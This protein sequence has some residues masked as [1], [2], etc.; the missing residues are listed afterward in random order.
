MENT[1][2]KVTRDWIFDNR[3]RRGAWTRHQIQALGLTWPA[4]SGWIEKLDGELI[5]ALQAREFEAGKGIK[6]SRKDR[7]KTP[8]K[9]KLKAKDVKQVSRTKAA[10]QSPAE[11]RIFNLEQKLK[12]RDNEILGLKRAVK[13]LQ[14]NLETT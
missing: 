7:D 5:T 14:R 8:K 13:Y 1:P 11:S 6:A 3:T 12:A 9:S 10:V 4:T 2:F